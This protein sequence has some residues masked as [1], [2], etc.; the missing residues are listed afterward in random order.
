MKILAYFSVLLMVIALIKY[1]PVTI[2]EVKEMFT[3]E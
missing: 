1:L 3:N 2:K